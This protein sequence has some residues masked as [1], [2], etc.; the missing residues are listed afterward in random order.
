MSQILEH[1]D[2]EKAA[3]DKLEYLWHDPKKYPKI[4]DAHFVSYA[5]ISRDHAF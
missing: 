4:D 5:T 3:E 2:L 1:I